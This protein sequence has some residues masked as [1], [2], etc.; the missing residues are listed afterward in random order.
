MSFTAR[1]MWSPGSPLWAPSAKV[2]G[3]K[4]TRWSWRM[5]RDDRAKPGRDETELI[6]NQEVRFAQADLMI[7]SDHFPLVCTVLADSP[8]STSLINYTPNHRQI[9]LNLYDVQVILS[10]PSL[11]WSGYE[12]TP[13]QMS[14]CWVPSASQ[15]AFSLHRWPECSPPTTLKTPKTRALFI[16]HIAVTGTWTWNGLTTNQTINHGSTFFI[17]YM[18]AYIYIFD[19]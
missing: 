14:T 2:P 4:H 12:T 1:S 18:C 10:L 17:E 5:T 13:Q 3:R 11:G 6:W 7:K 19:F 15:D 9:R 8:K 16:K